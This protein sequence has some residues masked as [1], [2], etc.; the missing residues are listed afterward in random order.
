MR[1]SATVKALAGLRIAIGVSS[2]ATPRVAGRVFGLDAEANPQAPYL[3][4]LFGVRDVAL[5][6]GALSSDGEAERRWL[7]A[8]LVCDA[9]DAL[10]GIAGGRA[11]YLPPVTSVLV[12][13]TALTAAA[14]GAAALNES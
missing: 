8:G 6:W 7:L 3:A 9:A 13:G 2:W 10:A 14:L 4:R 12:T 5:G 1:R 11:R